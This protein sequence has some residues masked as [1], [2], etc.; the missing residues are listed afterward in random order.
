[1]AKTPALNFYND[2]NL[3][4]FCL[5]NLQEVVFWV[6]AKGKIFQVNNTASKMTGYSKAELKKCW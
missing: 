3:L 2:L 1:M 6:N 4:H 5:D